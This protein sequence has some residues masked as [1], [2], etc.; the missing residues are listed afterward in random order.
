MLSA[1]LLCDVVELVFESRSV[2]DIKVITVWNEVGKNCAGATAPFNRCSLNLSVFSLSVLQ[3]LCLDWSCLKMYQEFWL[4]HKNCFTSSVVVREEK[5]V[6][7]RWQ[8]LT[9]FTETYSLWLEVALQRNIQV[10]SPLRR[11]GLAYNECTGERLGRIWCCLICFRV[12]LWIIWENL[13]LN[14][15]LVGSSEEKICNTVSVEQLPSKVLEKE[16]RFW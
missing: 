4:T 3:M 9:L 16:V 13:L 10:V 6:W 2:E 8:F 5:E 7:K 1:L 11:S 14:L 15:N 12:Y